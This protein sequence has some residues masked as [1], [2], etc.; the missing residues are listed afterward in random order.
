LNTQFLLNSR[1]QAIIV[2]NPSNL[3]VEGKENLSASGLD[4]SLHLH[5]LKGDLLWN[6]HYI[7]TL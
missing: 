5:Q 2:D 4:A 7:D 6:V 3:I 1:K